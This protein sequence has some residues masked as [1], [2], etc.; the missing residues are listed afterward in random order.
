MSLRPKV[1]ILR[2]RNLLASAASA[3]FERLGVVLLRKLLCLP[4]ERRVDG[5]EFD[6]DEPRVG[7]A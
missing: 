4:I 3:R 1:L 5:R 6:W 7:Q 2:G